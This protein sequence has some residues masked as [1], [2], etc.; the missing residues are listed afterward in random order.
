[1]G[2]LCVCVTDY[3]F[4]DLISFRCV[5]KIIILGISDMRRT[6]NFFADS[7]TV[8]MEPCSHHRGPASSR[9]TMLFPSAY[10]EQ[11]EGN[12]LLVFPH[13]SVKA[14]LCQV[15]LHVSISEISMDIL[16]RSRR[17]ILWVLHTQA[18]NT[19]DLHRNAS[20]STSLCRL[21]QCYVPFT[22]PL[23][24]TNPPPPHTQSV[25]NCK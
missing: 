6:S 22:S 4:V 21:V 8:P 18:K 5:S 3:R 10:W 25:Q 7:S 23:T 16:H 13:S 20:K 19:Q 9:A 17:P 11:W 24:M 1:M 12:P 14:W 15:N 2:I